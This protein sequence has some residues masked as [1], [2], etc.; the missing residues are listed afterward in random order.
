MK[1][2]RKKKLLKRFGSPPSSGTCAVLPVARA[3]RKKLR[4]RASHDNYENII[5]IVMDCDD[6]MVT[7][8]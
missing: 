3:W 7:I 2:S 1:I 6:M 5:V 8:C 4:F